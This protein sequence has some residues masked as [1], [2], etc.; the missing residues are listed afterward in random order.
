MVTLLS[1]LGQVSWAETVAPVLIGIAFIEKLA[2]AFSLEF[3]Q[4]VA[5]TI[6]VTVKV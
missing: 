5:V 2:A 6:P 4:P 1:E 3:E